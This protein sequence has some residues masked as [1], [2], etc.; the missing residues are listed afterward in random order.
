M[1]YWKGK[2]S[3]GDVAETFVVRVLDILEILI[4]VTNL[5]QNPNDISQVNVVTEVGTTFAIGGMRCRCDGA[6]CLHELDC[7]A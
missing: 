3:F 1:D 5:K 7:Q 6:A 2:F 4:I